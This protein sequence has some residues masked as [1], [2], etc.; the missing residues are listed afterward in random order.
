MSW[1]PEFGAWLEG[2]KTR[3]RIWAP[4]VERLDVVIYAQEDVKEVVP[5]EAS[6]D[7]FFTACTD[8]AALGTRYKYRI[9]GGEAF[10][11]PASRY[12]SDGV[13][14]PSIVHAPETYPWQDSEWPG[15]RYEDLVIYELHL[16]TFSPEGTFA[17]AMGKLQYLKDL[18]ITA[19]ELMPVADFPGDRGWGY[20]GVQL[21]A[22]ARCYGTP[23]DLQR[24]V[25]HAHQLGLAV[26]L[27]VVYN[28]FGPDGNYL[29]VYGP[30]FESTKHKSPWG[31]RLN[32]DG[33]HSD[34]VRDFFIN[35]AIYWLDQFH[36]DGLRLDATQA[37]IDDSPQHFLAELTTRVRETLPDRKIHLI[38]EDPRNMA[39]MLRPVA[40]GGYGLDGVWADDL[41]H[42]TRCLLAGDNEGYYQDFSG[43]TE[44][45][46]TTIRQGWFFT[47]QESVYLG[48]PRG[49]DPTGLPPRAF[50]VCIQN[51]DQIGNRAFGERLHHQV[52]LAAYRAASAMLL[53]LPGTPLLFMGQEWAASTPFRFF[54]DH[55]EELGKLVTAG[56]REEFKH[57]SAFSDPEKRETI[58]DPQAFET[59]KACRLLWD[60][61]K[62]SPHAGILELYKKLLQL[63]RD[64]PSLY[65]SNAECV[66]SA[67][68]E[69]ALA[70]YRK[71]TNGDSLL[72]VCQF[73][74]AGEVTLGGIP[75]FDTISKLAW[76]L[77]FA[78]EG[79]PFSEGAGPNL[80]QFVGQKI[81]RFPG[82]MGVIFRAS[83]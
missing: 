70:I 25:D 81:I 40:E 56:R 58:P 33:E 12:Q 37:I 20:D 14:G 9:D 66:A 38:A 72:L 17:G 68:N 23:E 78:T 53:F 73:R 19:V 41:H 42:Q 60:E 7:G 51:H 35:N 61:V 48:Q 32:F 75:N 34:K 57:F 8:K 30:H 31:A 18:G 13:H 65:D 64:E 26:L 16:G 74:G 6:G 15:V 28:H 3:F 29:G 39:R 1:R 52:D 10:P 83:S 43:T 11:D 76:E 82:P 79:T 67:V 77:D 80:E 49:T 63:R 44:D 62:S 21:F 55:N 36:F 50:L 4:G 24:L 47:G 22:P 2:D 54:A 69:N 45:L 46:A 27:D 71:A 5:L 59:F